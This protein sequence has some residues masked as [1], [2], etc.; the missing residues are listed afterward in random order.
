M[1]CTTYYNIIQY[2]TSPVQPYLSQ[3]KTLREA[4]LVCNSTEMLFLLP[5]CFPADLLSYMVRL[6]TL[7]L[8][9]TSKTKV[10]TVFKLVDQKFQNMIWNG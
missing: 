8:L 5:T 4:K 9:P 6:R 3:K 10:C 2:P 7:G 1:H